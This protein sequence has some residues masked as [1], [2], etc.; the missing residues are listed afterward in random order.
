M[1][2]VSKGFNAGEEVLTSL[3]DSNNVHAL[4]NRR[5]GVCLNRCGLGVAAELD[6]LKH[7]RV[8]A[9]VIELECVSVL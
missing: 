4:Q 1:R 7:H 2:R 9:S 3:G 5:D 8:K 6:V